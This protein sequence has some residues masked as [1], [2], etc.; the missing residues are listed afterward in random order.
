MVKKYYAIYYVQKNTFVIVTSSERADKLKKGKANLSK[1]FLSENEA[2]KWIEKCKKNEFQHIEKQKKYYAVYLKNEK[3][4]Y[5]LTNLEE[6]KNIIDSTPNY[7]RKF[8]TRLEAEKWL[9]EVKIAQKDIVPKKISNNKKY[10]A[11][12][13]PDTKEEFIVNTE[14][15]AEKIIKD[16]KFLWKKIKGKNKALEWLKYMKNSGKIY[17]AVF[18]LDDLT[19][20]VTFEITLMEKFVQNREYITRYFDMFFDADR[21]IKNMKKLYVKGIESLFNE[22]SIFFDCGTGRGIG[23]EVRVSDYMGNSILDKLDEYKNHLNQF[24]NYNLGEIKDSNYGELYGLYLALLIAIEKN[25]K[26]IAGDSKTVIEEW[27]LGKNIKEKLNSDI[28]KLIPKVIDLR[29]DFENIG[30]E[31]KYINGGLNPADLGFHKN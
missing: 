26:V 21:W 18:F 25:I 22:N 24:G 9:E 10:Y 19:S 27:S 17:Y 20:F 14:K 30:G 4:T 1:K 12:F 15:E 8:K 11:I 16:K 2:L 6:V 23:A 31:I 5:I 29:K 13:L 28:K 7:C 3:N